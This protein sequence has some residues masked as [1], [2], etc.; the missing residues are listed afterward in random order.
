MLDAAMHRF[1]LGDLQKA[2]SMR[3]SAVS[4]IKAC[5]VLKAFAELNQNLLEFRVS[6]G[7][8]TDS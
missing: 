3:K 5:G 8:L 2:D 4:V 1:F 7:Y 6:S